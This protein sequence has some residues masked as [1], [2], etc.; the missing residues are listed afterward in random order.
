MIAGVYPIL[1]IGRWASPE[2]APQ[3]LAQLLAGGAKQ[4]QLRAKTLPA[5]ALLALA[6]VLQ[7]QARAAGAALLINDRPDVALAAGADGVHLGQEDLPPDEVRRWLPAGM[8]IGVSCHDLAQL[9]DAITRGGADYLAYGPIFETRSKDRPDP[10]VGLEGLRAARALAGD[11][12]LVA[13][14]GIT[15][16][17]LA[18]VRAAGA[19]AAAMISELL[20]AD[21]V[22]ARTREAI[23]AFGAGP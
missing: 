19:T 20:G 7:T 15:V 8:I 17:R 10:V 9:Q 2:A 5:G 4:V 12:P 16:S 14:G 6:R 3:L 22:T 11:R 21:D 1:D 13:I 23:A 18:E